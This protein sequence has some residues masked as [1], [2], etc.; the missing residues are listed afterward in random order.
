M[1][2]TLRTTWRLGVCT[3]LPAAFLFTACVH[4][5]SSESPSYRIV[6]VGTLV[7]QESHTRSLLQA[8]SAVNDSVVWVSGHRATWVRTIDGGRTWVPG[9]MT[10]ADSMLEFRDVHAVDANTAYLLAAGPGPASRIYKTTDAGATWQ[11]QFMN[12]DTSAFYDCFDFYDATHGMAVSDAVNG[13]MIVIRTEDG[14]HWNPVAEGGMPPAI[15]G[16][17][18][19]AASG[20]CLVVRGRSRAWFATEAD[21]GAR[22]YRSTDAGVHWSAVSTP[23]VSGPASGVAALA[24][25]DD[26]HGM[27]LGGRLMNPNDRSDSVAAV[28]DDGGL[29]WR[30]ID[31]PSFSGAVYGAAAVPGLEGYVV[32]VGPKGLDWLPAGARAW[33]NASADAFWAVGFASKNAGW[34][35]GPG[36]RIVRI[37]FGPPV[38]N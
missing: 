20:T 34:A 1:R 35:V 30:L 3:L 36:G 18:S 29:T 33:T 37:A 38:A 9:R 26:R 11:L 13:R 17:G 27:A 14:K 19:P 5:S 2:C 22:V 4:R 24:F 6:A 21:S 8:V 28:T 25:W 7:P 15:R 16:E 12:R 31:R 10:G 32:A 23:V